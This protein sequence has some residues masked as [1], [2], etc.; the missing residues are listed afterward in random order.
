[1]KNKMGKSTQYL[2]LFFSLIIM[3]F[4][5]LH[6]ATTVQ[7]DVS[8]ADDKQLATVLTTAGDETV[9]LLR[10][11][12]LSERVDIVGN[13]TIDLNNKKLTLA[14]GAN[15]AGKVGKFYLNRADNQQFTIK[16][17]QMIGGDT[18][19]LASHGSIIGAISVGTSANANLVTTVQDISH[20]SKGGFYKGKTSKVVF[21]GKVTLE[22]EQFNVRA[23]NMDF[24]GNSQNP[25][26]PE[27][28]DFYGY[29]SA[30]GD[31]LDWS[32]YNGGLNLSFDGYESFLGANQRILNINKNAKVKLKNQLKNQLNNI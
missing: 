1:M 4:F 25:D 15:D 3:L 8:V 19:G 9:S 24:Y 18:R 7:A 31:P 13:K 20:N 16:N 27:N 17:G 11:I 28:V 14:E 29:A 21:K 2:T 5:T 30:D 26:D 23:K 10:D 32:T 12:T 6:G 22:N